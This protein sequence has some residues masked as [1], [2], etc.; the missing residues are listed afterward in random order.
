MLGVFPTT[1]AE[2]F[3]FDPVGIIPPIFLSGVVTLF[4]IRTGERND[5]ANIF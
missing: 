1:G 5:R 3:Q 4:T 2:L